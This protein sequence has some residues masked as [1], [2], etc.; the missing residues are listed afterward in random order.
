ML[1]ASRFDSLVFWVGSTACTTL[2]FYIK[3]FLQHRLQKCLWMIY[4]ISIYLISIYGYVLCVWCH[5]KCSSVLRLPSQTPLMGRLET[6]EMY[7]RHLGNQKRETAV[8]AGP[9]SPWR[10]QGRACPCSPSS[11]CLLLVTLG[12]PWLVDAALQSLPPSSHGCLLRVSVCPHMVAS[13]RDPRHI[14]LRAHPTPV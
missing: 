7:S 5:A 12:V 3:G 11:W 6:A 1:V 8:W 9:C 13:Y 14:G 2:K 4:L 10:F